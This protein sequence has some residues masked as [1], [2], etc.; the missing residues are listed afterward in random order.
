[1]FFRPF[2]LLQLMPLLMLMLLLLS[3]WV[4]S[5][6]AFPAAGGGASSLSP[7]AVYGG[8]MLLAAAAVRRPAPATVAPAVPVTVSA[9]GTG[10]NNRWSQRLAL[11]MRRSSYGGGRSNKGD[12]SGGRG[13][14]T[15]AMRAAPSGPFGIALT[16]TNA[17]LGLNAAVFLAAKQFP[18]LVR[19][20]S[21]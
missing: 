18:A 16:A 10:G 4:A 5:S 6:G 19:P 15:G 3:S 13:P 8:S 12:R 14:G 9:R 20:S 7:H 21:S 11:T 1:M 2:T 17:L